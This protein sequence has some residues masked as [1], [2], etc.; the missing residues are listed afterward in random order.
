MEKVGCVVG[1]SRFSEINSARSINF[2]SRISP[3]NFAGIGVWSGSSEMEVLKPGI[4]C[5]IPEKDRGVVTG[6]VGNENVAIMSTPPT[7]NWLL[8][9]AQK[10]GALKTSRT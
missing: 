9:T 8:V 1:H 2:P 3:S 5:S 7:W 4:S 10:Q 6:G